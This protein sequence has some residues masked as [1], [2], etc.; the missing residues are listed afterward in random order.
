MDNDENNKSN[1]KINNNNN[2][3]NNDNKNQI[4]NGNNTSNNI[5]NHNTQNIKQNN[6][7]NNIG[8]NESNNLNNTTTNDK[9][10]M[11]N[12]NQ[13][14]P[15][16]IKKKKKHRFLKFLLVMI[17]IIVCIKVFHIVKDAYNKKK[18]DEYVANNILVFPL[19]EIKLTQEELKEDSN[20]DGISNEDKI[21]LGLDILSD[22]TDGDGLSD[23]DEINVYY[24]DPTK[25]S[26]SGDIL[27][28]GYKVQ[29][30]YDIN[31]NYG[32]SATIKTQ[33]ENITLT[34]DDAIDIE[35]YYKEY[36]GSIPSEY[37][38]AMQP[39]RVYSFTGQI[40]V[41]IEN[42]DYYEVISYDNIN[43]KTT[44]IKSQINQNAIVFNISNDNPILIVYKNNLLDKLE[45]TIN[46]KINLKNNVDSEYIL[47]AMPVFSVIFDVPIY[48][49]QVN[50]LKFKNSNNIVLENR[51]NSK[52]DNVFKVAVSYINSFGAK[53]L[54]FC[55]GR[56]ENQLASYAADSEELSVMRWLLLYK[57][58]N[59]TT[60]LENYL[61]GENTDTED[62]EEIKYDFE[63]KYANTKGT[64]YADSGFSVTKN[65]FNFSNLSTAVSAGG[66]CLGFAHVTTNMFNEGKLAK[67]IESRYDL[68]NSAYN[69]IWN[70][71]LYS[72][73]ATSDLATYADDVFNNEP[74]LNSSSMEKPD[75][76]VVKTI[77]Y[78]WE[79]INSKIRIKEFSWWWNSSGDEPKT[80]YLNSNTVENLVSK[81][82]SGKIVS[83]IMLKWN[84]G[85]H[86]I[87]A[88]KIVEDQDDEDILYLKAYDNNFPA[89][90]GW[91][92][93]FNDK[94][95]Y[96]ITITLKRC[97]KN[98]IFGGTKTYYLFD[99]NPVNND[100]YHYGNFNGGTDYILFIDENADTV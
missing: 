3:I 46:S 59:S 91:N 49:F 74:L 9:I 69:T 1:D 52:T 31:K 18:F 67:S 54:D 66:V 22:D 98:T 44:N 96:D 71:Q 10:N 17:L 84:H 35:A 83:V 40:E 53:V 94:Q 77:E 99:Y 19:E 23:F 87:N 63:N 85:G 25:Y 88:Y 4:L 55:F 5:N 61:F 8:I 76:E 100:G 12:E 7:S 39:F 29:K 72:Y 34:I 43:K 58:I 14:K 57:H 51:L 36:N 73:Q 86:A 38:L 79:K 64:Y 47:I 68:S 13:T 78:Y 50:D 75:A 89:D 2:E 81:F 90:M 16:K 92:K 28:D 56:I 33:N 42:P 20:S 45:T 11:S 24:S 6:I 93:D 27:S 65:A 70:K 95:K 62:N 48:V 41:K 37:T 97:Y 32:D 21:K 30:G 80:T 15:P 26:T 60:D 82:K